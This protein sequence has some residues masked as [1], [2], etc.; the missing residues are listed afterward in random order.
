[1]DRRSALLLVFVWGTGCDGGR[2]RTAADNTPAQPTA[3]APA[4]ADAGDAVS[5]PASLPPFAA[6]PLQTTPQFV[7][8]RYS[9]GE[10]HVEV[11][12]GRMAAMSGPRFDE[13]V[14]MSADYPQAALDVPPGGG[15]GFYECTGAGP[16]ERCNLHI[17]LRDGFH[18]ELM[19]DGSATRDDLDRVAAGLPL[20]Q[21]ATAAR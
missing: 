6:E 19:S 7:R 13:W 2:A 9:R 20:R 18:V 1:M 11:T 16:A 4:T 10:T 15:T 21:L 3:T 12:V 5:L 14:R 17:Q 8:R